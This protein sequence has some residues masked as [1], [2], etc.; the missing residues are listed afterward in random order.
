M[1]AD[2][3]ATLQPAHDKHL[4]AELEALEIAPTDNNTAARKMDLGR[5]R[6]GSR[7]WEASIARRSGR[8]GHEGKAIWRV[9]EG[10]LTLESAYGTV[11]TQLGKMPPEALARLLLSEQIAEG[12]PRPRGEA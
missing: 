3:D 4:E 9:A 2:L 10:L 5:A 6:W 7:W 12:L 11:T 1:Q 8:V